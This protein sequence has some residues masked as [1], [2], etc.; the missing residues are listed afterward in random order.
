VDPP[1]GAAERA[2]ELTGDYRSLTV[3]ESSWERVLGVMTRTYTVGATDEGYL[4]TSRLGVETQRWVERRP[5]VYEAVG[6]SDMLV[7]R[8]DEDGRATH[9]FR[10]AFGP[11]TYERVPWYESL[12]VLQ[13]ILGAGVVAFVSVL[14]LWL[15]GPVWR[16]WRDSDLPTDRERSARWLLGAVSL[17]WLSVLVIFLFAWIN[18]NAEAASPSLALQAGKGLRWVALAGTV[19]AVV[20]TGFAWRDGYWT[21]LGRLHYSL[22]T[23]LAILFAWQ[24]SLLGVLPL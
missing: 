17:L 21:R 4:T 19:G 3:S 6:G 2:R 5:G 16:R 11:A 15:G 24:L 12:A 20:A 7:F 1:A 10:H 18:F 8:F 14:L 22:V 23:G 13:T 9:M